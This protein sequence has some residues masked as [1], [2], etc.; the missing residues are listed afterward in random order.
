VLIEAI[1]FVRSREMGQTAEVALSIVRIL[2]ALSRGGAVSW[3]EAR[4]ILE[5]EGLA[6]YLARQNPAL[7]RVQA[8]PRRSEIMRLESEEHGPFGW[9]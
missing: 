7:T 6:Q 5:R 3:E 8:W 4:E 9:R 2:E 1:D